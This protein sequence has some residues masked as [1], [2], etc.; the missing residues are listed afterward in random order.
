[1]KRFSHLHVIIVTLVVLTLLLVTLF[2][3]WPLG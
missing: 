1:M 3:S 2:W